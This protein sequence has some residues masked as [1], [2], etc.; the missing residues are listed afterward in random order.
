M[1][2]LGERSWTCAHCGIQQDRD[3]NAAKNLKRLATGAF[4]AQ[5]ALPVASS[6]VTS[7]TVTDMVSV[8]GGK[9]TP[10][11]NEYG[12]QDGSGQ[13]KNDAQFGASF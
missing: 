1:L 4:M 7:G 9:V 13:E 10:V 12:Q 3:I 11:S 8:G 2:S 6:A 5:S